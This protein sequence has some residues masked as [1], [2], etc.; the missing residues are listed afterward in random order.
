VQPTFPVDLLKADIA[1][2]R[3]TSFLTMNGF[4]ICISKILHY[5][6]YRVNYNGWTV[7]NSHTSI[8]H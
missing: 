2:D 1:D 4:V 7:S 6:M 8:W 3:W 5:I